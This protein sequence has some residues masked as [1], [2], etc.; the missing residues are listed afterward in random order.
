MKRKLRIYI[1]IYHKID[2]E[3]DFE[4]K[5]FVEEQIRDNLVSLS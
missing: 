5:F 4:E 1:Y 2:L 3:I